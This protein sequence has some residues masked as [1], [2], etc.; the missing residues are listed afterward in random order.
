MTYR[1]ILCLLCL[2]PGLASCSLL[3]FSGPRAPEPEQPAQKEAAR[4]AGL[5]HKV[6]PHIFRHSFATHL[7]RGG[8]DLRAVQEMLGHAS[9][10]TTQIY[11]HLSRERLREV[12]LAAH[13]REKK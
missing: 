1:S 6:T 2:V 7:L 13:P 9:I 5:S 4:A 8:A 11:T 10:S 12:Y 3:S